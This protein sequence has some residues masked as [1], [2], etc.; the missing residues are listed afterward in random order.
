MASKEDSFPKTTNCGGRAIELRVLTMADRDDLV[1]FARSLPEI[2]LQ[3]LRMD[4]TDEDVVTGWIESVEYGRRFTIAARYEGRFV[5]Y[6]SLNRRELEWMRHLGEIR[7]IVGE[8]VRGIGLGGVLAHEMFEFAKQAGLT[9]VI[10][11]MA[12]EQTGARKMFQALG[13]SA[14]A[15]LADWVIDR[16]G[17]TRDLLLMSYDVSGLN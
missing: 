14:E 11:Q 12:R 7:V 17:T 15:L 6:G 9:K 13:F 3:F 2:D 4:I 10:A 5:G 8:E 1:G 16:S